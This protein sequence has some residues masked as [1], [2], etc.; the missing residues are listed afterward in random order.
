MTT[1]PISSAPNGHGTTQRYLAYATIQ[2]DWADVVTDVR[3]AKVSEEV[4]WLSCYRRVHGSVRVTPSPSTSQ[5]RS[6][7]PRMAGESGVDAS[8]LNSHT[9][10]VSCPNLGVDGVL[11]HT[12]TQSHSVFDSDTKLLSFDVSP[13]EELLAIGGSNGRLS[14]LHVPD[15]VCRLDLTQDIPTDISLCRFFP[16]GQVLLTGGT[17]MRLRVWS[18][19]DGSC[20]VTLIGHTGGITDTALVDRGRTV[21]SS[22][23]DGTVRLWEL[24]SSRSLQ[25]WSFED[26]G[27]VVA[28]SL[29]NTRYGEEDGSSQSSQNLLSIGTQHGQI[30][31]MDTRTHDQVIHLN[32]GDTESLTSMALEEGGYGCAVAFASGNVYTFDLRSPDTPVMQVTRNGSEITSVTWTN[33]TVSSLSALRCTTHDGATFAFPASSSSSSSMVDGEGD[34]VRIIEEW[35]GSE[36]ETVLGS[37]KTSSRV[38]TAS[39]DNCIRMY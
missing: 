14:V 38:W 9:L 13:G 25:H 19:L 32:A 1:S 10:S 2:P 23:R 39:R 8:L 20:P 24:S 15:G 18:A 11:I 35:S 27:P 28:L 16:S 7:R 12:P 6:Q 4:F 5:E 21:Y 29:S 33:S 36:L 34:T 30:H 22:S 17:D 26:E 37:R 31:G 3:E